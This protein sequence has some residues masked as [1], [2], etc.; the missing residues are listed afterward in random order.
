MKFLLCMKPES[1]V[2]VLKKNTHHKDMSVINTKTASS[3]SVS[4]C[5]DV[6]S[7]Q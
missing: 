4:L 1:N 6:I 2:I 3:Y 5:L 7:I